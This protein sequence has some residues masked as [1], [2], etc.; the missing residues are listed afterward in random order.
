MKGYEY[1][2]KSNLG[3]E[4]PFFTWK[5]ITGKYSNWTTLGEEEMCIRD[6]S[7]TS[8]QISVYI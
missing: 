6:S 3:Y 5:D 8:L 4:V 2:A 1:L 7:Y